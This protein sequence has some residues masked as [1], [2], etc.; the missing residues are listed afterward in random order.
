MKFKVSTGNNKKV[1]SAR[2][3]SEGERLTGS[4]V[5]KKCVC[6]AVEKSVTG[7]SSLS[8]AP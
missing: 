3:S 6:S 7:L 2:I 4:A 1:E 5:S 8:Y